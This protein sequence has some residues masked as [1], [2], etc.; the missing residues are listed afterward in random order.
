MNFH[1][2][3]WLSLLVVIAGIVVAS[4]AEIS[5]LGTAGVKW[6]FSTRKW[7]LKY[8]GFNMFGVQHANML[9]FNLMMFFTMKLGVRFMLTDVELEHAS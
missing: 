6:S 3:A 8:D 1:Q 4:T 2:G 7:P 9:F 5:H